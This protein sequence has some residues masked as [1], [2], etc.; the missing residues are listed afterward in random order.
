MGLF[1]RNVRSGVRVAHVGLEDPDGGAKSGIVEEVVGDD[2]G[3]LVVGRWRDERRSVAFDEREL[4]ALHGPAMWPV[5][6]SW[7]QFR[8]LMRRPL[9]ATATLVAVVGSAGLVATSCFLHAS[10]WWLIGGGVALLAVSVA[11]TLVQMTRRR[12]RRL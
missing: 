9:I 5:M 8:R 2:S 4:V 10:M 7:R 12:P 6:T 1:R 11:L 3:R